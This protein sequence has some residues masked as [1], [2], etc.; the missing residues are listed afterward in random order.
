MARLPQDRAVGMSI[1][2]LV[3]GERREAFPQIEKR[4]KKIPA[5]KLV[6]WV[7]GP[8]GLSYHLS[9]PNTLGRQT[10]DRV[11]KPSRPI[12]EI[13]PREHLELKR[14]L[15]ASGRPHELH[16]MDLLPKNIEL[17][18]EVMEQNS[19]EAN[20]VH[21]SVGNIAESL[22]AKRPHIISCHNVMFYMGPSVARETLSS[23]FESLHPGG[24]L[25]IAKNDAQVIGE[26]EV[27][28]IVGREAK[29]EPHKSVL[30]ITKP[31]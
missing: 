29:I 7:L 3:K 6:A 4:L 20:N 14:M 26:A 1:S 11:I 17:A 2:G 23:L 27:R 12:E 25:S 31:K 15:E 22:P 9:L 24:M 10:I 5:G 28:K 8:G 21:Y 19:L 16:V 13:L 30:L 18:R